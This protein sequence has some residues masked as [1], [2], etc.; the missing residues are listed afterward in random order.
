[1]TKPVNPTPDTH[2]GLIP[3]LAVKDGPA[4]IAFYV[5]AFGASEMHRMM[6]PDGKRVMHAELRI[7]GHPFFLAEVFPEYGGKGPKDLGG[8]PVTMHRYTKDVDAAVKQA[9][10][11]GATILMPPADMFWG[12]RYAQVADPFG[13]HWSLATHQKDLTPDEMMKGMKEA[14]AEHKPKA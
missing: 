11:A 4:A 1:M 2:K 7:D 3:H 14:F 6:A 5:K 9:V 10:A 12:D 8:T 13:H